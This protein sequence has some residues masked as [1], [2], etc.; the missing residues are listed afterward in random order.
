MALCPNQIAKDSDLIKKVYSP[1]ALCFKAKYTLDPVFS[2]SQYC[3]VHKE[4]SCPKW[5]PKHPLSLSA[6]C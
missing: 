1:F 6:L 2:A 5:H 4:W 3:S